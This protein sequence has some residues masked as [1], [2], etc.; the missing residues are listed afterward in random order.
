M[1]FYAELT[2]KMMQQI[3]EGKI[4]FK[5]PE[6]VTLNRK[7]GSRACYF[8]CNDDLKESFIDFLDS[9]NINYQDQNENF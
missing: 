6:G 4:S 9:N 7:Q 8:E 1:E 2:R 5:L 3:E